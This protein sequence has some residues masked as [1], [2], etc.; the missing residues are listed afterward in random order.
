MRHRWLPLSIG[1]DW[2]RQKVI[3]GSPLPSPLRT[4]EKTRCTDRPFREENFRDEQAS[5]VLVFSISSQLPVIITFHRDIPRLFRT[6][7][8]QYCLFVN[9]MGAEILYLWSMIV[10]SATSNV[11]WLVFKKIRKMRFDI[12]GNFVFYGTLDFIGVWQ[13]GSC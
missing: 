10:S 13:L 2:T 6:V 8:E 7:I 5:R 9:Q 12:Y 3:A 1:R 11:V 4:T